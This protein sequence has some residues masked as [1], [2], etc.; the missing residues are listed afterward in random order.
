[1]EL[2]YGCHLPSFWT[3]L[4][5]SESTYLLISQ[6]NY[7]FIAKLFYCIV[8]R[9]GKECRSC[10]IKALQLQLRKWKL[11]CNWNKRDYPLHLDVIFSEVKTGLDEEE[12]SPGPCPTALTLSGFRVLIC[13]VRGLDGF[14]GLLKLWYHWK[15][16]F[17]CCCSLYNWDK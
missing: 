10:H 6:K 1:M 11:I 16:I 14:A 13:R 12:E 2:G 9:G 7:V 8:L 4:W 5:S 3:R 15:I 17:C